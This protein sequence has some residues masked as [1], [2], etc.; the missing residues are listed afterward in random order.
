MGCGLI[1]GAVLLMAAQAGPISND[2]RLGHCAERDSLP[3]LRH[4][5]QLLP[6]R[7][8]RKREDAT[9]NPGKSEADNSSHARFNS[10]S[11]ESSVPLA[12]GPALNK[13]FSCRLTN[14]NRERP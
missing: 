7:P 9:R 4:A 6:V 1:R 13:S 10:L 11:C 3:R 12:P 5:G 8:Q 14:D 2:F